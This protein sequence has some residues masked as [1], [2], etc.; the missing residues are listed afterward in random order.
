MS[1]NHNIHIKHQISN[2]D[3]KFYLL[4]F[5]LLSALTLLQVVIYGYFSPLVNAF[6]QSAIALTKVFFVAYFFM[7]LKEESL[8]LKFLASIPLF[9]LL[10][11]VFIGVESYIR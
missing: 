2:K 10:Y 7:H 5:L 11:T 9:A 4:I 6:I 1:N 3:V 8:W